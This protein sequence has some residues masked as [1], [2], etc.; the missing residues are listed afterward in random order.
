ML[1]SFAFLATWKQEWNSTG[2]NQN[3]FLWLNA[4]IGIIKMNAIT[5][6]DPAH[7]GIVSSHILCIQSSW[8]FRIPL[9]VGVSA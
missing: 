3:N 4:K 2:A 6:P 7:T 9:S 5:L 1:I 8:G